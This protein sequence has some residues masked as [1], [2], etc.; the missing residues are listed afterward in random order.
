MYERYYSHSV[1][2]S[3]KIDVFLA[4]RDAGLDYVVD[5]ILQ[6]LAV[7]D[8]CSV[9]QVSK[10]WNE[11][12]NSYT[13]RRRLSSL[14][15]GRG[16]LREVLAGL[17]LE[18]EAKECVKRLVRLADRWRRSECRTVTLR[19]ESSVLCVTSDPARDL[20]VAGLNSGEVAQYE[21]RTGEERRRKE[22][23]EKGVRVVVV[24][25]DMLY[26]GSYDGTVKLWDT[27][28]SPLA[29]LLLAVAV[30]DIVPRAGS[31]FVSGDGGCIACYSSGRT[32]WSLTGGEMVNCLALW[33]DWLVS[34]SDTG[35]LE[36]RSQASGAV[37]F[38]LTGHERGCGIS[39]LAVGQMGLW[40]ASFDCLIML[41]SRSGDCLCVLRGHSDPVRCL[42]LDNSRVVT[43]DYR[44]FVMIWD[45]RDI[46]DEMARFRINK[47]KCKKAAPAD[48]YRLSGHRVVRGSGEV[49]E[50]LQ[51]NSLLEH[52]GNVTALRLAGPDVL[53]SSSRDR[54]INIHTFQ[55]S[56]QQLKQRKSYL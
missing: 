15:E 51:H 4:L 46:K 13:W 21:V 18:C 31:L 12:D 33:K 36:V 3:H 53:L 40:S 14:L 8:L 48:I 29:L 55:S 52:R 11:L 44:G 30:T 27:D 2:D 26:T 17:S 50:V 41:W 56:Q 19:E 32:V 20:V 45:M 34:G 5:D 39:G 16:E 38:S 22:M 9:V 6:L 1:E 47:S 49:C 43:G 37:Q 54:T 24:E 23:H 42:H 10:G 35:Q 7:S 28:W 25:G